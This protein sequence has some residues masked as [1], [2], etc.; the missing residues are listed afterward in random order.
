MAENVARSGPCEE[1][2]HRS[3]EGEAHP[4]PTEPKSCVHPK[5]G[6]CVGVVLDGLRLPLTAGRVGSRTTGGKVFR[7]T[8]EGAEAVSA[9]CPGSVAGRFPVWPRRSGLKH[10]RV[11]PSAPVWSTS[12]SQPEHRLSPALQSQDDLTQSC[13]SI[14]AS[15]S[16][17]MEGTR[18][19][20]INT[21][22]SPAGRVGRV[23][24]GSV[25]DYLEIA[26]RPANRTTRMMTQYATPAPIASPFAD[27]DRPRILAPIRPPDP[28]RAGNAKA[29]AH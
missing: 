26:G 25:T 23:R 13:F 27:E 22:P 10:V 5:H 6:F 3:G 24:P 11:V 9:T 1:P 21:C 19:K 12:T 7:D 29:A 18:V 2:I 28:I 4:A 15:T 20:S 16:T 17:S 8:I 14:P